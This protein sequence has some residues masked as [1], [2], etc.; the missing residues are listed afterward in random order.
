MNRNS[1]TNTNSRFCLK[2]VVFLASV[3]ILF[4]PFNNYSVSAACLPGYCA[5]ILSVS[6]SVS[7]S[8]ALPG[9]EIV[10]T[11]TYRN[12]GD[13]RATGIVIKDPFFGGDINQ[14]Y[15]NFIS[16]DPAPDSGKDIWIIDE[17]LDYNESGRI[18]VRAQIKPV[19]PSSLVQITNQASIDSNEITPKYSNYVSVFIISTCRLNITQ[20]A[21]SVSDSSLFSKSINADAEDEVEFSL[22]LK[23][24][25]TNQAVN[26]RV[27][28]R[29][30]SRLK[31]VSDSTIIDG[32]SI[33]DGIVGDGIYLGDLLSGTTKTIKFRAKIASKS[34][35]YA[36]K[37]ILYNYGYANASGCVVTSSTVS[38]TVTGEYKS[39]AV[40][41]ST[42]LGIDKLVR[43][44]TKKSNSWTNILYVN[45]GDEIEFLI[46][47]KSTNKETNSVRVED[48]LP[49]KMFYISDSTTVDGNYEVDGITTKNVYL[50]SVY[51]NLAR[52]IKFRV[53]IAPESEFNLYPISLVNEAFAWGNDGKEIKD[54]VKLI[55]N[56]PSQSSVKGVS[57]V[58]GR[59][60]SVIKT[61][62]NI[63]KNQSNL[64]DSFFADPGEE[65][66]FLIQV[67]NNGTVDV[68]NVKVQD[69]LPQNISI[70]DG[71]TNIDG[72]NWG[73]DV[74][75]GGL[76]LGTLKKGVTK[77]IKFR[78]RIDSSEKFKTTST[79]LINSVFVAGDGVSQFSDQ[80]SVIIHG[81]GEVLGAATI[82]TGFNYFKFLFIFIISGILAVILYC[83][84]REEK[85]LEIF[86][87][88]KIG[89]FRKSV[90][91][92]YFKA[93]L[94]FRVKLLRLKKKRF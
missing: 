67:G 77:T 2:A 90:I 63:T 78:A 6:V 47:I 13:V 28:D 36:G 21:R 87:N 50:S 29:L 44:V 91:G 40:V 31:Y 93:K 45:P 65:V 69:N 70:I 4:I 48:K 22:E 30:P 35:F 61:G 19:L 17:P 53:K 32:S 16:A 80:V 85:L 43:N 82:K 88:E 60:L 46:K 59:S 49:P 18:V 56:R 41:S 52:E 94:L 12:S 89:G 73:G 33:A 38:I 62:R 26:T 74:T 42:G 25:G 58:S 79:T 83:R 15:L 7:K 54:S 39:L 37:N 10:Y 11:I 3:G 76:N 84:I 24:L 57:I 34:N 71:S 55:I 66:E 72:K 1:Y 14:N 51:P 64:T 68:D 27:W 75:G 86:N 8:T 92:L 5:P 81:A 23:S 9:D 20:T